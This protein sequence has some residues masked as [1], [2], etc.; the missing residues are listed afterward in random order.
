MRENKLG[1]IAMDVFKDESK[2]AVSLRSG[3]DVNSKEVE[4]IKELQKYPNVIFTP[5]NSFNTQEAVI[6]KSQQSVEQLVHLFENGV[7]KWN[8]PD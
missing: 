2:L 1:G 5:H 7:F 6:R 8:S 4:S 3:E